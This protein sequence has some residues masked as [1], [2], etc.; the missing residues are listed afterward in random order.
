MPKHD[1]VIIGTH[2]SG[3]GY[4]Q[5]NL[6][7]ETEKNW[8]FRIQLALL[9]TVVGLLFRASASWAI[10]RLDLNHLLTRYDFADADIGYLLFDPSTGQ[11]LETHRADELRIPA[12][13]TKVVTVIA[14]LEVLGADYRFETSLFVTG[15]VKART[16]YGS[17]YLRGGGDPTLT[18]DDLHTFVAMLQQT[19]IAH[20]TGSFGFDESFLPSIS[21]IDAQQ[22][23]AAP[24][25][26]GLSALS[27]NYNRI[28]LG[29]KRQPGPTLAI[30]VLSPAAGRFVPVE[31]VG[32]DMLPLGFDR[33]IRFL[34]DGVGADRWLLS[35]TLPKEGKK[36]LPV[37]ANPGRMTA[38]LFRTLC[39]QHNIEL[40]RPESISIPAQAR[41]LHIHRSE[42]LQSIIAGVLRYSNNLSAELIGQVTTRKLSN[43]PLSLPDS[44]IKLTEW[45]RRTLP[46]TDWNG[47]VSANHSGL[48]STSRHSPRQMASILRH[49]W[50]LT[51][52]QSSFP[53]LLP[54]FSWQSEENHLKTE[55]KVKTGTMNYADGLVG[56]LTTT[57]GRQLGFAIMLTD[58]VS[59][60]ELDATLDARFAQT[61]PSA[62][63]WTE[64]AK[65]I[66]QELLTSW[67]E[68]Y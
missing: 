34:Y 16:L 1:T 51:V 12:S 28:Q 38:L 50:T 48:N 5:R 14:A 35:P 63:S 17:V 19:G 6:F 44:A 56:F 4:K 47:F 3:K 37:K 8:I 36:L 10:P 27:I 45:Y 57:R 33:R 58:F 52:G 30:T 41:A 25:N 59:R 55:V 21:Q 40:P 64:R 20:I 26:P 54:P 11:P 43:Q 53:A 13:T 68:R 46:E 32:T 2:F 23:M 7:C 24:Y 22:P 31:E 60:A 61:S 42:P 66:E 62:R 49:G 29:W 9:V 67:I 15:E 18:T 39:R 65:A